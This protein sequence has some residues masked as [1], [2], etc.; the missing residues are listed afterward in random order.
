MK[1]RAWFS[2]WIGWRELE[3]EGIMEGELRIECWHSFR[4]GVCWG[5]LLGAGIAS[6]IWSL[7]R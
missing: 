2:E 3:A 6:I 7:T 4:R 1:I 5:L